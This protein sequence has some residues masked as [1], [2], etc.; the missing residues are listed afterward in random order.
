MKVIPSRALIVLG[1]ALALG[2]GG[3]VAVAQIPSAD[4]TIR[5]CYDGGGALK[6]IDEGKTCP[7]GWK[8]PITWNQQGVP[9]QDGFS[10]YEIVQAQGL[11]PVEYSVNGI[12]RQIN[13]PEGKV[14]VGGGGGIGALTNSSSSNG[15]ALLNRSA[16]NAE[17]T[18]WG[19]TAVK[20]DGTNWEVGD[21]V[22]WFIQVACV[23]ALP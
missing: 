10:G 11:D 16:F 5:A 18:G 6:V 17:H 20:R 3:G 8:G 14:P 15:L 9:G 19:I 12:S 21:S 2:I 7:K 4:G 23:N 13:C 1:A 22:Q